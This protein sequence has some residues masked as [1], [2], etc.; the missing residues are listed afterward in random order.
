MNSPRRMG[1][2]LAA[3]VALLGAA[4]SARAEDV[5]LGKYLDQFQGLLKDILQINIKAKVLTAN[6]QL[7]WEAKKETYTVP[8][9][10]VEVRVPSE[11]IVILAYITPVRLKNDKILLQVHAELWPADAPVSTDHIR[12]S[13][14]VNYIPAELGQKIRFYPLGAFPDL[15]KRGDLD[16]NTYNLELEIQIVPYGTK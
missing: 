14:T 12:Y 16:A 3:S 15:S 7:I 4:T 2:L 6:E 8:G 1:V 10:E 11:S 5:D 9:L 13:T